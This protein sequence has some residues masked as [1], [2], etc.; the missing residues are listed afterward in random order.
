VNETYWNTFCKLYS[1]FVSSGTSRNEQEKIVEDFKKGMI[2]GII[3]TTILEE[4]FDIP[5]CDM[6]FGYN[7]VGNEISMRQSAGNFFDIGNLGS[8]EKYIFC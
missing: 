8:I 1:D 5:D 2:N 6:V 4:G 3:A 7:Y